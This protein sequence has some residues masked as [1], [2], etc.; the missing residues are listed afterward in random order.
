MIVLTGDNIGENADIQK[1]KSI[2]KFIDSFNVPWAIV[3]GNHDHDSGVNLNE[4]SKI[5]QEYSNCIYSVGDIQD[6]YGNYYYNL[7]VRDKLIY[8]LIFM[9]SGEYGFTE[10]HID[11]YKNTLNTIKEYNNG[12]LINSLLFFHIPTKE[13]KSAYDLY[14]DDQTIGEGK[15]NEKITVQ[16]TNVDI[17]RVA[18]EFGS[19]KAFI[20]GHDHKN[21]LVVDY[22]GIKLCYGLKTGRTYTYKNDSLGGNMFIVNHDES[23]EIKRIYVR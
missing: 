11:W 23:V 12:E 6:S 2:A 13:T 17:F 4:Q 3:M 7:K 16:E 22:K 10:Q 19:T 8:S 9:D 20:Y 21:N 14:L 1:V 15:I 5:Y 18:S